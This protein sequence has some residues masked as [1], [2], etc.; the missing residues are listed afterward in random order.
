M[1][2]ALAA[3]PVRNSTPAPLSSLPD[4]PRTLP[5][6]I[7]AIDPR[8]ATASPPAASRIIT[9]TRGR[10]DAH[11]R[12]GAG[13]DNASPPRPRPLF[14]PPSI[15]NGWE[16]V[17]F[18]AR[19]IIAELAHPLAS[20]GVGDYGRSRG[21]TARAGARPGPGARHCSTRCAG[22]RRGI[23]GLGLDRSSGPRRD[24][25]M[26]LRPPPSFAWR[27]PRANLLRAALQRLDPASSGLGLSHRMSSGRGIGA[28]GSVA[29]PGRAGARGPYRDGRGTAGSTPSVAARGPSRR[30]SAIDGAPT[31]W[32]E[33]ALEKQSAGRMIPAPTRTMFRGL[34]ARLKLD[35]NAPARA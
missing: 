14:S 9:A 19:V 27:D 15:D 5:V 3:L 20:G 21:E 10:P 25:L 17:D 32:I 31:A 13:G 4:S 23:D 26:A 24:A 30:C 29:R 12:R 6:A 35:G 8:R 11:D 7:R 16:N 2:W 22:Q 1:A 28:A 34:A 18:A 33:H